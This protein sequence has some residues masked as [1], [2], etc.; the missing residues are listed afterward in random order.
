MYRLL[1]LFQAKHLSEDWSPGHFWL[2]KLW[3]K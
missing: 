3:E 2:W 1:L